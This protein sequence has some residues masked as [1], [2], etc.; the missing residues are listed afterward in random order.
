M[1]SC[2]V[3]AH[4]HPLHPEQEGHEGKGCR[5]PA[6]RGAGVAL[7]GSRG[8]ITGCPLPPAGNGSTAQRLTV[9]RVWPLRPGSKSGVLVGLQ[10][11][12]AGMTSSSWGRREYSSDCAWSTEPRLAYARGTSTSSCCYPPWPI[13]K[14]LV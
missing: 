12:W 9:S 1:G 5:V 14:A 11:G 7:G 4:F 6:R 8:V 2:P 3:G 13:T 10:R